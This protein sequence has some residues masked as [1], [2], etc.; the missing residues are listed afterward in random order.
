MMDAGIPCIASRTNGPSDLLDGGK[1]GLLYD[2]GD[3][4]TLA[5][6]IAALHASRS[7]RLDMSARAFARIREASFSAGTFDARLAELLSKTTAGRSST[8]AG[9]P[10]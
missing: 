5:R 1:A 4:Q 10:R 3:W 7:M 9:R 2:I 6:H 8:P